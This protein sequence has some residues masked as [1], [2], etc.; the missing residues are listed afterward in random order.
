MRKRTTTLCL[1]GA[2]A[3]G[4]A[5]VALAT[6][7]TPEGALKSELIARG[8]AGEFRI[9]DEDMGLAAPAAGTGTRARRW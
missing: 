6:P 2:L 8:A 7:P 9:H 3:P 5:G 4:V 1:V